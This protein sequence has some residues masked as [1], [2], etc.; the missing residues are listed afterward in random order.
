MSSEDEQ[1]E[2]SVLDIMSSLRRQV[3]PEELSALNR[4]RRLAGYDTPPHQA[5][6]TNRVPVLSRHPDTRA[7]RSSVTPVKDPST[8]APNPAASTHYTAPFDVPAYIHQLNQL[9]GHF[10]TQ[11]PPPTS[12]SSSS[13]SKQTQPK[14]W[15][16]T[17]WDTHDK[18]SLLDLSSDALSVSFVGSAKYGDRD[19]AAIRANRSIPPQSAVYY[20]EVTV[21]DKGQ[22]GYIGIG[23]SGPN[24]SLSRLP[25]WEKD[26]WAL[27]GDDGSIFSGR[28]QGTPFGPTYGTG[29][30]IGV[31]VDWTHA[32][33]LH[34]QPAST[35]HH[36]ISETAKHGPLAKIFFTK[37][38]QM[39]G[40]SASSYAFE[41]VACTA[42][43]P[44]IGL[45]TPGEKVKVNFGADKFL[46]DISGYARV[47]SAFGA[48]IRSAH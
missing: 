6:G 17:C 29:D 9:S 1:A 27:H 28:G 43:Y 25:G 30:V 20:F 23:V 38:G 36:A 34:R 33:S 21:L 22:A 11:P 19:A 44:T 5:S 3:L 7:I 46:F 14:Y 10:F 32:H 26:S 12:S 40:P 16:P 15:L 45:R 39:L 4:T 37:N 31:G 42:L 2:P 48:G 35:N 47:C 13:S 24:V 18:S 8:R 41:N